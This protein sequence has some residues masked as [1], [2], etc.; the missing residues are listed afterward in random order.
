MCC[1]WKIVADAP[2]QVG[3]TEVRVGV[4]YRAAALEGIRS[5]L[6][7]NLA[8]E[9]V[10]FWQE[11]ECG[12]G[13]CGWHLRRIGGIRSV[14]GACDGKGARG[15]G[16][17]ATLLQDNQAPLR[18]RALEACRAVVSREGEPVRDAWIQPKDARG[19]LQRAQSLAWVIKS[20]SEPLGW[21]KFSDRVIFS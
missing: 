16:T 8:R 3:L 11:Y 17:A 7:P 12:R 20:V 6:H 18:R 5:E 15:G 2:M 1:D 10:L 14:A 13:A 21:D 4:P 19:N 9:L